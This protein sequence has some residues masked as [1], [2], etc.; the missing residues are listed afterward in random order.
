MNFAKCPNNTEMYCLRFL[1]TGRGMF[2]AKTIAGRR[3]PQSKQLDK[4][5]TTY[6]R[7]LDHLVKW[8]CAVKLQE[9]Y[10]ITPH[11]RKLVQDGD[12][13]SIFKNDSTIPSLKVFQG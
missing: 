13:F 10:T 2:T 12:K 6:T 7:I 1:A 11:G 8:G 5:T 9:G 4:K 3:Y